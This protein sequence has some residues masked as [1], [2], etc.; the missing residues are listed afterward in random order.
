LRRIVKTQIVGGLGNQLFQFYAGVYLATRTDS[1]LTLDFS[2]V[3]VSGT[4]HES[5]IN[6]LVVG[7]CYRAQLQ[8]I[9]PLRSLIWRIFQKLVREIKQLRYISLKVL[10]VHQSTQI[11]FDPVIENLSPPIE[12]HG[13]Y[14]SWRYLEYCREIGIEDPKLKV[15]SDW[16]KSLHEKMVSENAIG[17]HVRRGDYL[18][19]TDSFGILGERY[20]KDALQL[21]QVKKPDAIVY[22]F[23]DDINYAQSLFAESNFNFVVE[24]KDSIAAESMFLMSA[25]TTLIIANSTF[26]WWGAVLGEKE[27]DV[28]APKKW[29]R[30][31]EDPKD[32]IPE[33]WIRVE[34]SWIDD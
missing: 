15:S 34:S 1:E 32:L 4:V 26:S 6:Q 22:V 2:K 9:S 20:Y 30:N 5:S 21:A 10:R 29:F 13:Y 23:S 33:S 14:Q 12:I 17:I 18:S 7:K 19:L 16:Y 3:A 25:C 27:K 8:E 31:L 11:G 28:Y 24:P